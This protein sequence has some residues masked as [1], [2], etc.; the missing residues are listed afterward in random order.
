[1]RPLTGSDCALFFVAFILYIIAVGIGY[2]L[3]QKSECERRD[4]RNDC[5]NWSVFGWL[6]V[7]FIVFLIIAYILMSL[8][9]C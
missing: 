6:I 5:N 9:Q 3:G 4:K 8:T 2:W 7:G 1:M